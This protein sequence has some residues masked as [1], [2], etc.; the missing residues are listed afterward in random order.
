MYLKRYAQDIN[1]Y[2]RF[3]ESVEKVQRLSEGSWEVKT[4]KET[5]PADVVCICNGHYERPRIPHIKG[6]ET[7]SGEYMH[8][9]KYR[10]PSMFQNKTVCIL[11]SSASGE[12]LSRE[13]GEVS[14][15]CYL[16][17]PHSETDLEEHSTFGSKNNIRRIAGTIDEI[18][19]DMV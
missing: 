3:N 16:I 4:N 10:E 7:F 12:D 1:E 6:I 17:G 2:I 13:I 11:G 5:M 15:N 14:E 8:S 9:K 19:G 18:S